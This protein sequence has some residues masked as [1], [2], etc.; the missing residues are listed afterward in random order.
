VICLYSRW[1]HGP[2]QGPTPSPILHRTT[3]SPSDS[4]CK[5]KRVVRW[6][7]GDGP[8][9]KRLAQKPSPYGC[10]AMLAASERTIYCVCFHHSGTHPPAHPARRQRTL[11]SASHFNHGPRA[12]PSCD[13]PLALRLYSG[14]LV[15][16]ARITRPGVAGGRE[17]HTGSR[18]KA[19]ARTAGHD[20]WATRTRGA[21]WSVATC[22][23][24]EVSAIGCVC[25]GDARHARR[26]TLAHDSRPKL[27]GSLDSRAP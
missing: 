23:R 16:A 24:P 14:G 27:Y 13:G 2:H 11:P 5:P 21:A 9:E 3:D 25:A 12:R 4:R 6:R 1:R 26:R 8:K 17:R 10:S 18:C 7:C 15:Y 20:G 22:G 19:A